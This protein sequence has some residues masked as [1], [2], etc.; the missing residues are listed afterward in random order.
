MENAEAKAKELETRISFWKN[1]ANG[2]LSTHSGGLTDDQITL[3][4]SL[5]TGDRLIIFPNTKREKNTHPHYNML[6]SKE[7]NSKKQ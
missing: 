4:H 6:K 1:E 3:L 7:D 5:K 2:M